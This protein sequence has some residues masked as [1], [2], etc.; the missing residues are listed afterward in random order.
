[1]IGLKV[2]YTCYKHSCTGHVKR[3]LWRC[4]SCFLLGGVPQTYQTQPWVKTQVKSP[5]DIGCFKM[6]MMFSRSGYVGAL[7]H[8]QIVISS[9]CI[10]ATAYICKVPLSPPFSFLLEPLTALFPFMF[11]AFVCLLRLFD[12]SVSYLQCALLVLPWITSVALH[13]FY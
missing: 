13:W 7:Q 9:C 8:V 3:L 6:R 11:L 5:G 12:C 2:M 10:R 4:Q 1:M